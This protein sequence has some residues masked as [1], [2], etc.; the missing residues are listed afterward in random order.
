M[1]TPGTWP[2]RACTGLVSA[3]FSWILY[4]TVTDDDDLLQEFI[5]L[6][7]GNDHS[8]GE[9]GLRILVT[10]NGHS[11]GGSGGRTER[12]CTVHSGGGAVL[13]PVHDDG[14]AN[15]RLPRRIDDP[16]AD[17]LRV[18]LRSEEHSHTHGSQPQDVHKSFGHFH[19]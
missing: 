17:G 4:G 16:A 5:V 1:I 12:E 11:D 8:R 14:G 15:D 2:C 19:R 18:R 7:Q 6:F 10:Q 13:R 9:S 3:P